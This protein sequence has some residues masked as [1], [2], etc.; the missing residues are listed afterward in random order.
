MSGFAGLVD[1]FRTRSGDVSFLERLDDF[2][3]RLIRAVAVVAVGTAGGFY[4]VLNYDVLGIFTAPIQPFL[5]GEKLKFLSPTD[6][7]FITLKL[8]L[9]IG[10]VAA[11]P[12]LLRQLWALL[13]PLMLPDEKKLMAPAVIA[14]IALFAT[15]SVFCYFFVLPLMLQFTM[16]FQTTSLEQSIVIGEYLTLVLR[17]MGAFGVA[18]ELPIVILLGTVLGIVTP[19]FLASKRRHAIAIIVVLSAIVTP[20]DVTSQI[21]LTVPV[22]ILYEI[23]IVMSRMIIARRALRLA[24][25]SEG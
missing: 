15:G 11:L 2:R 19:E 17:L 3:G 21:L 22:I 10:I 7:F 23:S 4:V 13:A 14:G 9:C 25:M 8:A 16:G 20:P 18:F 6:P 12:Y 24:A 5:N 1:G